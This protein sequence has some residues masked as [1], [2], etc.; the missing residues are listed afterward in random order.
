MSGQPPV[1]NLLGVQVG[2]GEGRLGQD[3]HLASYCSDVTYD[4]IM[5]HLG[6]GA[7]SGAVAESRGQGLCLAV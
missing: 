1:H 3:G 2:E 4:V 7:G 6:A 5:G